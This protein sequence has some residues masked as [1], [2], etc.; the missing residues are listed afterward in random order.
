MKPHVLHRSY[1]GDRDLNPDRPRAELRYGEDVLTAL[2]ALPTNHFHTVVTSPPY[3]CLRDYHH[4][5]SDFPSIWGGREHCRHCWTSSSFCEVCH[6]WRGPLGLE[7]TPELFIEHLITVCREIRR[8]LRNDGVFWLNLGDSYFQPSKGT[9]G[10]TDY[11]ANT[12]KGD[13]AYTPKKITSVLPIKPKDLMG[14]PWRVALDLQ[15][16]GWFL[17]SELIWAKPNAN[18]ES[19]SD[20]P[21][22]AHEHVFLLAKSDR[23]FYDEEMTLE[24]AKT[25]G[26]RKPRSVMSIPTKGITGSHLAPMPV[27]LARKL[28]VAGGT[29][30]GGCCTKCGA[31][32]YRAERDWAASCQCNA[33]IGRC[34]VLDPFAKAATTGVAALAW[35][36]DYLGLDTREDHLSV[37]ISQIGS[38]EIQEE[39][40]LDAC[41][42][43][44]ME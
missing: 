25:T 6:A 34:R 15:R 16:E 35:E 22:N 44:W 28:V 10:E 1:G 21:T 7:P 11:Y 32:R 17:R 20:R 43:P 30:Q 38:D 27:Q 31:P 23:Y 24:P 39:A 4:I 41:D 33:K 5:P 36:Y 40:D 13:V 9:G 42:F 37:A 18:P 19:A 26:L 2:R 3:Y 14:I 8:I 12:N 29:S